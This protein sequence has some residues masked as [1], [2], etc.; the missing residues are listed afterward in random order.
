MKIQ[1]VSTQFSMVKIG[2][3]FP[4][5]LLREGGKNHF[6]IHNTILNKAWPQEKLVNQTLSFCGITKL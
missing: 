5:V 3:K 1:V 4:G 6:E 2:E